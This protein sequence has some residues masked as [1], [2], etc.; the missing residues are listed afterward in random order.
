VNIAPQR[1]LATIVTIVLS[2]L[3]VD[4]LAQPSSAAAP[5]RA[6]LKH[7]ETNVRPL[8]VKHCFRCHEGQDAAGDV[9]WDGRRCS[10]RV[11]CNDIY[12]PEGSIRSTSFQNVI[13]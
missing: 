5:S 7:F 2:L 11:L 12:R 9:V 3:L 10:F 6:A 4:C 13:Q 8:L 1:N